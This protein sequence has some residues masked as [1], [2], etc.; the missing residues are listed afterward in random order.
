M[1]ISQGLEFDFGDMKIDLMQQVVD[2]DDCSVALAK[3]NALC[4]L[5]LKELMTLRVSW[6]KAL[7][8][9]AYIKAFFGDK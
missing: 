8:A 9:G 5:H 4:D 2:C 6:N 3:K 1:R 7:R